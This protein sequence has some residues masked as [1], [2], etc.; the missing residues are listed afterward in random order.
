MQLKHVESHKEHRLAFGSG[1]YPLSHIHEF[2]L[3]P[4]KTAFDLQLP[5][6]NTSFEV[7]QDRQVGEHKAQDAEVG[8][9]KNPVTH[10]QELGA[11][12]T[13]AALS[14]QLTQEEAEESEQV[15]H[16]GS[17]SWQFE[18]LVSVKEL[19]LQTQELGEAALRCAFE[20]QAVQEET[21]FPTKQVRQVA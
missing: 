2:G 7:K 3:S 1:K 18:V 12:E 14:L 15:R 8:S 5:Q 19:E 17:Q 21:L 20:K 10:S 6:S 16:E 9:G 11:S 13:K 4:L